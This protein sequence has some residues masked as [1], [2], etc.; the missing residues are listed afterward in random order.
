MS[1]VCISDSVRDSFGEQ[2]LDYDEIDGSKKRY[3]YYKIDISLSHFALIPLRKNCKKSSDYL[4]IL[5]K[6][7]K[8]HGFDFEKMLIIRKSEIVIKQSIDDFVYRDIL[9]KE[10]QIGPR[11]FSQIQ[12]YKNLLMKEKSGLFLSTEDHLYLERNTLQY[13]V[14]EI[15]HL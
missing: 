3:Y 9:N 4:P 7:S 13:F 12:K 14:N 15:K 10:E 2:V 6:Q 1:I 11:V 8:E 5:N